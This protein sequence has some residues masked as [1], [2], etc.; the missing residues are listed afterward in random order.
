MGIYWLSDR[1]ILIRRS[2]IMVRIEQKLIKNGFVEELRL[3][4]GP[5]ELQVLE[6]VNLE[7]AL[8]RTISEIFLEWNFENDVSY[9]VLLLEPKER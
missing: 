5:L 7:D 2:G 6:E 3:A 4:K 1:T 9:I 8:K